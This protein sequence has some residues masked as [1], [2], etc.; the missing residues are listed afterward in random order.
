MPGVQQLGTALLLI[1][2]GLQASTATPAPLS[3]REISRRADI[4]RG[5]TPQQ[6]SPDLPL[7]NAHWIGDLDGMVERREIRALVA[8]DFCFLQRGALEDC[9]AS[10]PSE[11]RGTELER[12]VRERGDGRGEKRGSTNRAV[13]RQYLQILRVLQARGGSVGKNRT[14][15]RTGGPL[16]RPTGASSAAYRDHWRA[17]ERVRV[18]DS[19]NW[20]L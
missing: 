1:A 2:L 4:A 18:S 15:R 9:R 8:T 5:S 14:A 19:S 20:W 17:W 6:S 3:G 16:M 10:A 7:P 11:T 12:V 13:R